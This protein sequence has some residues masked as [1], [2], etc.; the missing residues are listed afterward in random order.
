[1]KVHWFLLSEGIG[2]IV[3]IITKQN[4]NIILMT[5]TEQHILT[6]IKLTI[7]DFE[8]LYKNEYCII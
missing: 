4:R 5:L 6:N 2:M 7:I 8:Y 3:L 1:M